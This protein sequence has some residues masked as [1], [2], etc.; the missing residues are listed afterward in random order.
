MITAHNVGDFDG[1][2]VTI[3]LSSSLGA[4]AAV[5]TVVSFVVVAV[6]YVRSRRTLGNPPAYRT[7]KRTIR[8]EFDTELGQSLRKFR[9]ANDPRLIFEG[10]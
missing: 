6:V 4:V 1:M 2:A 7:T 10:W 9:T 5:S 3:S 8:D